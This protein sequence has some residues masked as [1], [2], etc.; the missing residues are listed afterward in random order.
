[1]ETKLQITQRKIRKGLRKQAAVLQHE[2]D[3]VWDILKEDHPNV[4]ILDYGGEGY[5]YCPYVPI[6]HRG[7]ITLGGST[8]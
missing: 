4:R 2:K 1:M 5:F 7:K 8:A 3:L 6:I